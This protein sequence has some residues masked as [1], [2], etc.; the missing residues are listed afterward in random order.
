MVT[1]TVR[2]ELVVPDP[3]ADY[4]TLD[5]PVRG[6]LDEATYPLFDGDPTTTV[7]MSAYAYAYSTRRGRASELD[8]VSTGTLGVAFRN[9]TGAFVDWSFE[10]NV[11]PGRRV[12]LYLDE[13][14]V[15]DGRVDD[16]ELEYGIDGTAHASLT[17]VDALGVLAETELE[18]WTTTAQTA[19]V[20]I[21][22]VLDR[23]EVDYPATRSVGEGSN[24]I[25]A[26]TVAAEIGRAHV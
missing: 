4:L 12:R 21:V 25:G 5:D 14:C 15:F 20:R 26:D 11:T 7:D 10:G 13:V 16:W 8:Q 23:P 22:A 1:P 9:Y 17:A 6:E 24:D 3:N 18:E 2:V 19:D